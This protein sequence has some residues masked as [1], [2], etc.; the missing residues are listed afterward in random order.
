M[1]GYS[2]EI[3][4]TL[5]VVAGSTPETVDRFTSDWQRW[6]ATS[7]RQ[8][9]IA[10][11]TAA[12][13]G[14]QL[15]QLVALSASYSA[16]TLGAFA[17]LLVAPDSAAGSRPER[18]VLAAVPTKPAPDSTPPAPEGPP[19][20]RWDELTLGSIRGQLRGWDADTLAALHAYELEH[21][22]R[23]AVVSMLA[24]RIAKTRSSEE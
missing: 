19:V 1:C 16:Q 10:Y 6:S 13:A 18:P 7:W 9:S 11:A 20:P 8:A 2:E 22:N 23:P 3:F 12:H 4:V 14:Y 24:K 21:G 15:F 17:D 5:H